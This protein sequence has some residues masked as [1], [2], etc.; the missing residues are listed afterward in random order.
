[1][2]EHK[3]HVTDTDAHFRIDAITRNISAV[4][5]KSALIQGDHNSER[6]TFELSSRY[7]EKHDMSLCNVVQIHYINIDSAKKAQTSGVY[8]V[9]DMEVSTED[10]NK[11]TLSWLIS[12]NATRY[13]GSLSFL[14]KFK[15]VDDDGKVSYVWN[16]GI[17]KGISISDG[18]DNGNAIVEDYSDIL[19]QWRYELFERGGITDEQIDTAVAKY[20]KE[21]PVS[22]GSTATIG[23]VELLAD[24]W[25]NAIENMLYS[26]IVNI[27]GVT[28]NSKVDLTP[29]V[30]QLVVFYEKDLTFVTENEGGVVTVYAIGQKPANNYTI[31]VTITEVGT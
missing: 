26:Q 15:C 21:N 28:K 24:K 11:V 3:H 20:L 29:S 12:E 18:M 17:F 13:S 8:E 16:S 22:A 9:E 1:M 19:V 27:D 10:D 6:F 23:V 14:I 30:E 31:Q 7:I 25:V 4:S 2:A 5:G